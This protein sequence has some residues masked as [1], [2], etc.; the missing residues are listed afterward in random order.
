M[1][2]TLSRENLL[3][4][5][6]S[7]RRLQT[8]RVDFGVFAQGVKC[9]LLVAFNYSKLGLS[10]ND[11][12]RTWEQVCNEATELAEERV[13]G[14]WDKLLAIDVMLYN[15]FRLSKRSAEIDETLHPRKAQT[16][17]LMIVTIQDAA[18]DIDKGK[19]ELDSKKEIH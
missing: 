15:L 3:L 11:K 13:T 19:K 14:D 7:V 9:G 17:D 5:I 12:N 16:R 4:I 2:P 1:E 18:E 6:E 8:N 10:E